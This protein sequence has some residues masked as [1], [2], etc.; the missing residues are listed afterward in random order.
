GSATLSS[1]SSFF[2]VVFQIPKNKETNVRSPFTTSIHKV[3]EKG[4]ENFVLCTTNIHPLPTTGLC[5]ARA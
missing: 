4:N 1:P 3:T 2:I 5:P